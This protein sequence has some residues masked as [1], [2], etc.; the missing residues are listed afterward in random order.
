MA[1]RTERKGTRKTKEVLFIAALP[2]STITGKGETP[3]K[4]LDDFDRKFSKKYTLGE[5]SYKTLE[6]ARNAALE[7]K[8]TPIK[9]N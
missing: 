3:E 7:V 5:G 4:A 2:E 1:E 9:S 6:Y 8:V